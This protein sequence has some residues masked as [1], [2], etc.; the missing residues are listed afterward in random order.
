MKVLGKPRV[1]LGEFRLNNVVNGFICPIKSPD[2][3]S[4]SVL[5]LIEDNQRRIEIAASGYKTAINHSYETMTNNFLK[6]I[7]EFV[8]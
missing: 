5:E 8:E 3:I 4:K 2:L 6:T 1:K 7:A